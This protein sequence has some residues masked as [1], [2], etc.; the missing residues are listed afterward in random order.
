MLRSVDCRVVPGGATRQQ[1]V[2]LGLLSL[3]AND[4]DI[5]TVHDAARPWASAEL[6]L[7]CIEAARRTG[8]AI[9]ALPI[10]DTLKRSEDEDG[11]IV[12]GTVDRRNLWAAQTPQAFRCDVIKS[13]FDA[14]CKDEYEG[15]DESVLV[16]RSGGKVEIVKGE[17]A[18]LKITT[19]DDLAL[20]RAML[21]VAGREYRVGFGYDVH[22]LVAGRDLWL[23]GVNIPY[24]RGL[25][26][27]SDADVLLHAV[28]DALLGAAG[29]PDIGNLFPNTD[30]N[31]LGISSVILLKDVISRV[32]S[33]G[34]S[35]GN[36]DST[37]I[38]ENP[39]LAPYV[40]QMRATIAGA[41]DID[42]K[43]VGVKA[44]TNEHVGALGA[45]MAVACHA[46][47]GIFKLP[48]A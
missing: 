40:D 41:L 27:H 23:G 22:R 7:R 32:R 9:A 31:L 10:F 5:I 6:H 30:P 35:P 21:G 39:K 19:C 28:C 14:A 1:S 8:A 20:S 16:E 12:G 17:R 24:E 37:V 18:N 42:I 15:T 4:S 38:A 29:L 46:V 44:T 34:W 45:G 3:A 13:A 25:D 47:V 43:Q 36:I 33:E 48:V 11:H 26:G 2:Y